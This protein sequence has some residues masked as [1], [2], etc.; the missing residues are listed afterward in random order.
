MKVHCNTRCNTL[1]NTPRNA[2]FYG[3][4]W[5]PSEK[6]SFSLKKGLWLLNFQK[7]LICL[8]FS[9]LRACVAHC[10]AECV[11]E[12]CRV[13]Q[14]HC[15]VATPALPLAASL[16]SLLAAHGP[17]RGANITL[18]D[19]DQ[20]PT[21]CPRGSRSSPSQY[22]ESACQSKMKINQKCILKL[23]ATR[24]LQVELCHWIG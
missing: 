4:A 19:K 7:L 23:T 14:R 11:A 9:A 18:Y 24:R 2:V 22:I 8:S 16:S 17:K 20:V 3:V 6:K 12:R 21:I 10:V 13:L 15:N 5:F 1:C